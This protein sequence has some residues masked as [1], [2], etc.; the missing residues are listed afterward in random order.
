M[1]FVSTPALGIG[2]VT[3]LPIG[4]SRSQ[5]SGLKQLCSAKSEKEVE[6]SH[7]QL[8]D[9]T[10]HSPLTNPQSAL[11]GQCLRDAPATQEGQPVRT[12]GGWPALSDSRWATDYFK[13]MAGIVAQRMARPGSD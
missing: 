4:F 9:S 2:G 12:A 3:R 5:C 6:V 13:R 1:Q 11:V 10:V 8:L 7:D